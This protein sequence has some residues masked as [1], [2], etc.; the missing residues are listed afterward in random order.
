M[1]DTQGAVS[2]MTNE[3][4]QYGSGISSLPV[5]TVGDNKKPP[6]SLSSSQFLQLVKN[7]QSL[8]TS[9]F[10]QFHLSVHPI[11]E[12]DTKGVVPF[13]MDDFIFG[14]IY[15]TSK[16]NSSV[17]LKSSSHWKFEA[18][19][20]PPRVL[21]GCWI[22]RCKEMEGV[23][24]E[25]EIEEVAKVESLEVL[26]VSNSLNLKCIYPENWHTFQ[27]LKCLYLDC[28]PKLSFVFSSSQLPKN[29]QVLQIKFCDKLKAVFEEASAQI[30]KVRHIVSV[31]IAGI[32]EHWVCV[33]ISG[34][35]GNVSDTNVVS[36][37]E[38]ILRYHFQS[39]FYGLSSVGKL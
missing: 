15:N 37:S 23:F 27:N 2:S 25:E 17:I 12:Q 7:N 9:S 33:A 5:K 1:K 38:C 13:Y 32:E 4:N 30:A 20:V 8:W 6:V 31:G 18:S 16:S 26:W 19:S 22:E 11:E 29:L 39:V 28:C 34:P 3:P 24:H 14:D 35:T 10:K 36:L 21:K